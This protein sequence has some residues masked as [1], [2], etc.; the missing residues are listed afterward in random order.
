MLSPCVLIII[1]DKNSS[2]RAQLSLNLPLLEFYDGVVP[3]ERGKVSDLVET[4]DVE[5]VDHHSENI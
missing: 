1:G 2:C 4:I 3:Y 5:N